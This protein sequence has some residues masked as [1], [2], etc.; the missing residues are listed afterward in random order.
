MFDKLL[1]WVE[2]NYLKATAAILLTLVLVLS[3]ALASMAHAATAD[4]SW[5]APT[6]REDGTALASSDIAGYDVEWGK[7]SQ[8]VQVVDAGKVLAYSIVLPNPSF[9][10]WCFRVRTRDSS[11]V[12]SAWTGP[13][14][15]TIAA[16]PKPPIF[17]T[18]NIVAYDVRWQPGGGT[19]LARAVGTVPL[20]TACGDRVITRRGLR[21]YHE[22]P[23]DQVD[24]RGL[25][26]SP[27]VVAE[28][29]ASS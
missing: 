12:V 10:Q 3:L 7:C 6:Q 11:G 18:V 4:L 13:V 17:T 8:A 25:P 27:I 22:V 9:G 24:L 1:D 19:K 28:C 21:S 15:K 29:E 16:P 23:L 14:T 2:A 5:T 26:S 20:G